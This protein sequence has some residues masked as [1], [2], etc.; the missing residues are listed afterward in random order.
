MNPMP[1]VFDA[2][3][4]VLFTGFVST[5]AGLAIHFL[6]KSSL[7]KTYV[8][9]EVF[10]TNIEAIMNTHQEAMR[11]LMKNCELARLGCPVGDLKQ[12]ISEIKEIQRLRT[13]EIQKREE[14]EDRIWRVVFDALKIPMREQ[15]ELLEGDN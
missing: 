11:T 2:M 6:T 8:T 9:R 4:L 13:I 3:H 15:N 1:H 14:H 7:S 10:K 5:I 12:A